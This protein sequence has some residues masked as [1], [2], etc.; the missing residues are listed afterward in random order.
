MSLLLDS[1]NNESDYHQW[2]WQESDTIWRRYPCTI[3]HKLNAIINGQ[4]IYVTIYEWVYVITKQNKM[5]GTQ[6]NL[7]TQRTRKIRIINH[8]KND[9]NIDDMKENE[10]KTTD[11]TEI[12]LYYNYGYANVVLIPSLENNELKVKDLFYRSVS[13]TEYEITLMTQVQLSRNNT[14]YETYQKHLKQYCKQYNKRKDEIENLFWSNCNSKNK[15]YA[16]SEYAIN[17]I[18]SKNKKKK[19]KKQKLKQNNHMSEISPQS[20]Q[21]FIYFCRAIYLK[22]DDEHTS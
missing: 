18:Q 1:P 7:F 4:T 5:K 2:E 15:Q 11:N 10:L 3:S 6:T 16:H 12:S 17:L 21:N 13:N 22:I 19:N 20:E 9:S 8:K 14:Q